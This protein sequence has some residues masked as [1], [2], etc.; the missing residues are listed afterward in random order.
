MMRRL[1]ASLQGQSAFLKIEEDL[2]RHAIAFYNLGF[3]PGNLTSSQM[4]AVTMYLQGAATIADA[5]RTAVQFLQDQLDKLAKKERTTS[6]RSAIR[7]GEEQTTL[8][9]ILIDCLFYERYLPRAG[10]SA[11]LDRLAALRRFWHYVHSQY[12]YEQTVEK[13]MFEQEIAI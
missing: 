5:T 1:I 9:E 8:G 13:A 3:T 11:G 10:V 12:R 4:A 6:W 7:K 2:L